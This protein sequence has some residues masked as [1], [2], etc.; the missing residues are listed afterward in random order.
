MNN[1]SSP[2]ARGIANSWTRSPILRVR[3]D[4]IQ[5]LFALSLFLTLSLNLSCGADLVLSNKFGEV[6]AEIFLPGDVP[7]L[8]G[9]Y[10][11]A[12][13]YKLK[14]DDRWAEAGHVIG[15]GHVS[16]DIDRK[17]N[18]RPAKLRKALDEALNE[19]VS[20]SGHKELPNLPLPLPG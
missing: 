17:A 1:H 15:F 11:H 18:N 12:A 14:P 5:P 4:S 6:T 7:V 8:R 20:K 10:V 19:F 3:F 16:I 13:N 2:R 9:L